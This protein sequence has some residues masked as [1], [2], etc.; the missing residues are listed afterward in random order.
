M[1]IAA[2]SDKRF[3]R[4][5]VKPQRKRGRRS[6]RWRVIKGAVLVAVMSYAG[7]RAAAAFERS[8][9]FQVTRIDVRGN[10]RLSAGKVAGLLEGLKGRN[11]LSVDLGEWRQRLV[12][13]SWVENAAVH[14]LLPSTIEVVILERQPFGI[15]RIGDDLYL[16]DPHGVLID[17]YGPTYADI[18]LPIIRG[19]VD[20]GRTDGLA[21]DADRVGLA[22][23]LLSS[24]SRR[25][26][27]DRISEVDVTEPRDA[28]VI[29]EGD[30]AVIK[31][32]HEDFLERLQ[33]YQE[34]SAALRERIPDIDYVDLRFGRHVYLRAGGPHARRA[35]TA[36]VGTARTR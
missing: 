12:K 22:A 33:S 3:R 32:G 6:F 11:I 5:H 2:P 17:E 7:Y 8:A 9:L 29:L 24:L 20:P 10:S 23:R 30:T 1:T 28:T 15:G 19:L 31:L 36:A 16:V 27:A 34:L 4:A 25:D 35:V 21:I 14:R 26:I 18:D 13:S